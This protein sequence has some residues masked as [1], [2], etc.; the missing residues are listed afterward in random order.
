MEITIKAETAKELKAKIAELSLVFG[1]TQDQIGHTNQA[2][3]TV[4]TVEASAV[5]TE[6]PKAKRGRRSKAEMAA[7]AE[8]A[9][10]DLKTQE[11][12]T[13]QSKAETVTVTKD[14]AQAA[15]RAL[16]D[17]KGVE[18]CRRVLGELKVERVSALDPKNY[19]ELVQKCKM[20]MPAPANQ[21]Q[22]LL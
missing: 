3:A 21:A 7:E 12:V 22:S 8:A 4:T 2:T 10:A 15:I 6:E 5:E 16:N 20:A 9:Q 13:E 11:T 18:E 1:L 17:A 19:A 14:E